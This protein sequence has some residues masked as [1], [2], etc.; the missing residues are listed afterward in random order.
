MIRVKD[1]PPALRAG[2]VKAKGRT[3]HRPTRGMNKLEGDW[4][5]V[6]EARRR[7]GELLRWDHEP[8][9]LKLADA[10][11]YVPDFRVQLPDGTIEFH[12]CKGFMRDDAAVKLKTAAALHPYTFRLVTR[13]RGAWTVVEV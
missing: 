8:E 3:E 1:L 5:I 13:K 10:T 9:K 6:L 2:L 7:A 4:S 12:E 11:Y